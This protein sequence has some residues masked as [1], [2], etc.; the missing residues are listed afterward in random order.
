[1]NAFTTIHKI[2]VFEMSQQRLEDT[3]SSNKE[4]SMHFKNILLSIFASL[5]SLPLFAAPVELD[6]AD[7]HIVVMRALDS[8]SGDNGA[9]QD[10]LTAVEEHEGGFTLMRSKGRDVDGFPAVFGSFGG[11]GS[12]KVLQGVIAAL[13]P[14][15]FKLA[16]INTR[17]NVDVPVALDPA[18]YSNFVKYERELY[19]NLVTSEGNPATLH[20]SVSAKKL[21]AG[22]LSLGTVAV[23]ADKYGSLGAN[24]MFNSGIPGDVYHITAS[25]RAAVVPL[26]LPDFDAS[27]YKSIDVRRVIQGNNDRVGQVIIA[28]KNNKTEDAENEALIK[29][30]VTLTG[31]DTTVE[32]IQAAR[33]ADL[34]KRQA[35]WDAC[36][37][38]GKC[39]Q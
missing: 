7:A 21:F 35:I 38:D 2:T 28:Y 5:F 31:A 12:D 30:I 15:H 26:D 29:A 33:D 24:S 20:R 18:N 1:M 36:V 39:K 9:S 22:V 11:P 14:L 10:S 27:G 3:A 4:K 32:A 17:F 34:A 16:Q 37:A 25:G 23:G 8:W 19:K 13:K 6:T